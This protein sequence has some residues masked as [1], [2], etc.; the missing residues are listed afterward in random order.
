MKKASRDLGASFTVDAVLARSPLTFLKDTINGKHHILGVVMSTSFL[1]RFGVERLVEYFK[2]KKVSV[3][4]LEL[5]RLS[6]DKIRQWLLG[7][8]IITEDISAK[9]GEIGKF[10]NDVV[11]QLKNPDLIDKKRA[12]RT[13]ELA[14]ECLEI[15]GAQ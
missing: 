13:I 5:E 14:I 4:P 3:K 6:L 9:W 15:L 11:H 7:Y 8:G 1:E 2:G 12:I 10:R